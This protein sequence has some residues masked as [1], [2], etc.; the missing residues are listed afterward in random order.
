MEYL[1]I[2]L[3]YVLGILSYAL[4]GAGICHILGLRHP[5]QA[6]LWG[7]FVRL[8]T[9]W[10][11]ITALMAIVLMQGVTILWGI[12]LVGLLFYREVKTTITAPTTTPNPPGVPAW[13]WLCLVLGL[14]FFA[15]VAWLNI[16]DWENHLM[17]VS[18]YQPEETLHYA[19][20]S[21]WLTNGHESRNTV[22]PAL[23]EAYRGTTPYHY[24][25]LYTTLWLSWLSGLPPLLS[26]HMVMKPLLQ[27]LL[28]M[29]LWGF[30]QQQSGWRSP[31]PGLWA[32]VILCF[33]F[34][35]PP[36]Y[37]P[38]GGLGFLQYYTP[39][40]LEKLLPLCLVSLAA[41]AAFA[42]GQT[43]L[44][45]G[46]FSMLLFLNVGAAPAVLG[47]SLGGLLAL[48]GTRRYRWRP[49]LWMSGR[50]AVVAVFF[51]AFYALTQVTV[52]E[53]RQVV[54][55]SWPFGL[56]DYKNWVAST[57]W[58]VV[59][60]GFLHLPVFLPLGMRLLRKRHIWKAPS[61]LGNY[62]LCVLTGLFAAWA[63]FQI[64]Y[65]FTQEGLQLFWG[66][67]IPLLLPAVVWGFSVLWRSTSLRWRII[68]TLC[69]LLPGS[70]LL[71]EHVRQLAELP[72]PNRFTYSAAFIAQTGGIL[73]SH[74]PS[75]F[76]GIG[77][78]SPADYASHTHVDTWIL[79]CP[80][81]Y[82]HQPRLYF[83][84]SCW[85]SL[86]APMYSRSVVQDHIQAGY[87]TRWLKTQPTRTRGAHMAAFVTQH[88]IQYGLAYKHAGIPSELRPLIRHTLT[89]SISGE[90]LLVFR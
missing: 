70:V 62:L 66:I 60:L 90:R 50:L 76:M 41:T 83:V 68:L 23:M 44:A 48:A 14:L 54:V 16:Y 67:Y 28:L 19:Q 11:A 77:L 89:D 9:G 75:Q 7:W 21:A 86:P 10:L 61:M 65:W 46:L 47:L 42:Q 64:F 34:W 36:Q 51:V 53:N 3:G 74:P 55:F 22:Q 31:L 87:Y 33:S 37:L 69:S 18:R 56:I 20:V 63:A 71:G 38:H 25:D 13:Q 43:I 29:G 81:I 82:L 45:L 39:L 85:D 27:A 73:D 58:A 5:M 8:V 84:Q 4:A 78:K 2:L 12:P 52:E 30:G 1:Q 49:V 35:L 24:P 59:L 32:M 17:L 57:L 88:K 15:G 80:A 79:G 40:I 26:L 6:S 72:I